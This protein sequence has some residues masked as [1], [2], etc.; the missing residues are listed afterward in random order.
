MFFPIATLE[1]TN[2]KDKGHSFWVQNKPEIVTKKKK[3]S[4]FFF[5]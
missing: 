3:V 2:I 1:I 4:I 5:C